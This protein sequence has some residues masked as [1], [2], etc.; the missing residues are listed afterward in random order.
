MKFCHGTRLHRKWAADF[1]EAIS[2]MILLN[3]SA[4]KF[5]PVKQRKHLVPPPRRLYVFAD[6]YI[7]TSASCPAQLIFCTS[8]IC[9][10]SLRSHHNVLNM[11]PFRALTSFV[12][13]LPVGSELCHPGVTTCTRQPTQHHNHRSR[14]SRRSI[15]RRA[16]NQ[17]RQRRPLGWSQRSL[18]GP[19]VYLAAYHCALRSWHTIH[20]SSC[21][22]LGG[23]AH[24]LDKV[25]P[26][27][28]VRHISQLIEA[29]HLIRHKSLISSQCKIIRGASCD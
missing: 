27:S 8:P 21:F 2:E 24:I 5:S 14:V 29:V 23:S 15:S 19:R 10:D 1:T 16:V 4:S 28:A 26:I 17:P 20:S 18:G 12:R 22:C 13:I 6:M 9:W 7:R 25:H 3:L 11:T